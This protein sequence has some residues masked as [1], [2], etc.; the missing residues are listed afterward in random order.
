[1][2]S[3]MLYDVYMQSDLPKSMSMTIASQ[4]LGLIL[5][6]ASGSAWAG[7]PLPYFKSDAPVFG[8]PP[9][10]P[11]AT[12]CAID[13]VECITAH[14][15]GVLTLAMMAGQDYCQGST[16]PAACTDAVVLVNGDSK[17][18]PDPLLDDPCAFVVRVDRGG[19]LL[20]SRILRRS[21]WIKNHGWKASTFIGACDVNSISSVVRGAAA[22]AL[23][24]FP[25]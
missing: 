25:W 24:A 4:T 1:M 6:L 18:S 7:D 21:R 22:P 15:S 16:K 11:V 20:Y 14:D 13:D 12:E 3:S 17:P 9:A 5:F 10:H 2:N 23:P 8:P 19:A